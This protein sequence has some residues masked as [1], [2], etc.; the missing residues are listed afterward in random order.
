[1][2]KPARPSSADAPPPATLPPVFAQ[3]SLGRLALVGLTVGLMALAYAPVGQF[4]TAWVGLAPWLVLVGYARS[5]RAVFLWS[6]LTGYGF[7]AVNTWWLGG[8]TLPGTIALFFY[9]GIWFPFVGLILWGSKVLRLA[10]GAKPQAAGM[11]VGRVLLVAAVWV[12]AEWLWGNLM[13]GFPWL[14]TGHS[15]TPILAM[16]QVADLTSVYGVSFWVLLV[17]ALVAFWF[18]N[19][20]DFRLMLRPAVAVAVVLVATLVYGLFRLGQSTQYPGPI[21]MV[22]QPNMPQDPS[23]EKSWTYA[24]ILEFHLRVNP[25]GPGQACGGRPPGFGRLVGDDAAATQP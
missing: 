9:M 15:Q 19:G 24:D 2:P 22:V 17:N 23:G 8:V 11:M 4:Y 25:R 6:W 3:R 18:L 20:R 5:K 7:F 13:T 14:Y 21:V 10:E 12:S 16:C 1:M